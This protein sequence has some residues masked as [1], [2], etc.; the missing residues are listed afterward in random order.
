MP[1]TVHLNDPEWEDKANFAIAH[2]DINRLDNRVSL[3]DAPG[4]WMDLIS[5]CRWLLI[6]LSLLEMALADI[7]WYI[8]MGNRPVES[9][10]GDPWELYGILN[11]LIGGPSARG[12]GHGPDG[13]GSGAGGTVDNDPSKWQRDPWWQR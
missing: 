12:P 9:A 7:L 10:G 1:F 4:A 3:L 13:L 2:L 5:A 8:T 6:E 11:S